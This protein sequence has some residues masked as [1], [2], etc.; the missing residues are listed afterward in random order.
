M[1]LPRVGLY[2]WGGPGTLRLLNTKYDAPLVDTASFLEMYDDQWLKTAREKVGATDM[3]VTYSWG[4]SDQTEQEDYDYIVDR[5]PLFQKNN[6]RTYAYIQGTNLIVSE[7]PTE[8]KKS[9]FCRDADGQ[10]LPYS[11]GRAMTCPNNP[12]AV[13]ILTD[14]VTK[15][16]QE[17]FD[18]IFVDNIFFGLP[19]WYF[20]DDM[21]SFCG[22]S[23]EH[24]Q[25]AFHE[26]F[27]YDLPLRTKRGYKQ[28]RDYLRFR[29]S[30]LTQVIQSLS[31]IARSAGKEFGVNLYD[32]FWH[33]SDVMFG[34]NFVEIE[35]YLDYYLIENHHL[36]KGN[37]HLLPLITSSEKPTFIVSYRKGIGFDAPFSAQELNTWFSNAH[38]LG[39]VPCLKATEYVS[40]G[41]WHGLRWEETPVPEIREERLPPVNIRFKRV[42]PASRL[43]RI[44]VPIIDRIL[45]SC[46][47]TYY[48]SAKVFCFVNR[49]GLYQRMMHSPRLFEEFL[50]ET[51]T[52]P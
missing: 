30:K 26:E 10:L 19:A 11:R 29:T 4:F 13:Q 40:R 45:P 31:S 32:P 5:L 49:L 7:F 47:R 6:I 33:T 44:F 3:W 46:I 14:R 37:E 22:C 28:V 2:A 23:C 15:A 42:R 8:G 21:L 27:G 41:T 35:P 16:A 36:V 18:A 17:D 25:K 52:E 50:S 51:V 43:G 24:C 9:P 38:D 34:Y 1:K 12:E 48:E 20:R 39:F